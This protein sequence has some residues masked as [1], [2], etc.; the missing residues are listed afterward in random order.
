MAA[1]NRY[2]KPI[3]FFTTAE[4][5]GRARRAIQKAMNKRRGYVPEAFVNMEFREVWDTPEISRR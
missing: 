5:E 2:G 3:E 1:I 4:N